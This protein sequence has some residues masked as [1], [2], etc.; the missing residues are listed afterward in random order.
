M[1]ARI[2]PAAAE[3]VLL[4][5]RWGDL[6]RL[7]GRAP[8]FRLLLVGP[9]LLAGRGDRVAHAGPHALARRVLPPSAET[10][11]TDG[12]LAPEAGAIRILLF[13]PTAGPDPLPPPPH[14]A[15]LIR[16]LRGGGVPANP[17]AVPPTLP[18][19]LRRRARPE[20]TRYLEALAARHAPL[21]PP[22]ARL[23]PVAAHNGRTSSRP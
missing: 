15:G 16:L 9:H 20:E 5:P 4:D 17:P 1:S 23:D 21:L 3:D 11:W 13:R 2:P 8:W 12:I 22:W 7:P 19:H 10:P 14:V 18:R 6:R